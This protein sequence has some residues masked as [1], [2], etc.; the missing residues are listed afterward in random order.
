MA[1]TSG[2]SNRNGNDGSGR[3]RGRQ[4]LRQVESRAPGWLIA[5]LNPVNRSSRPV[6]RREWLES[7]RQDSDLSSRLERWQL[8]VSGHVQGVGYRVACCQKARELELNGWVRNCRDGSVEV[9]AE[10]G[11]H[12]LTELRLWCERGP[13]QAEVRSVCHSQLTPIREDWFEIRA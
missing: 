7:D 8:I 2:G 9:Q 12:Q 4:P 3:N 6:K 13:Q 10:G 5:D 1:S 11:I